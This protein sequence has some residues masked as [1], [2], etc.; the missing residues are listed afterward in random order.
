MD[1]CRVA[2][3][4]DGAIGNVITTEKNLVVER[5]L[6][7]CEDNDIAEEFGHAFV[8]LSIIKK[9]AQ[10]N[11]FSWLNI[12]VI[13]SV[14]GRGSSDQFIKALEYCYENNVKV[15]HLSIGS[16][17]FCDFEKINQIVKKLLDKGIIIVASQS[18][19]GN[20]TYPAGI[21]G[22]IGVRHQD[23]VKNDD[24]VFVDQPV[25]NISFLASASHVLKN[26]R[27]MFVSKRVNSYATPVMTAH[28]VN[29]LRQNPD[30]SP[31][32]IIEILKGKAC[33]KISEDMILSDKLYSKSDIQIPVVGI[34]CKDAEKA[35]KI[36]FDLSCMFNN[37][38]YGA[39]YSIPQANG[40][41]RY[42]E[43]KQKE[44]YYF[45]SL[46]SG[47]NIIVAGADAE[48]S[49][50]IYCGYDIILTDDRSKY[51]GLSEKTI[52]LQYR[53]T[54][55]LYKLILKEFE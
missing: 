22:V 34:F 50:E 5:S 45:L 33:K 55:E 24:F 18:N 6:N 19:D 25:D 8:C 15:I 52:P 43:K 2:I 30:I 31:L 37:D 54:S 1:K 44:Y 7:I 27:D 20:L 21:E 53:C 26:G 16:E 38:G 46:Y 51:K 4:D 42:H 12:R 32:K 39:V 9:Y 13:D 23:D 47:C 36:A 41:N 29:E 40:M 11:D 49:D 14:S 17:E 10:C 3:I 48:V 35:G 28:V